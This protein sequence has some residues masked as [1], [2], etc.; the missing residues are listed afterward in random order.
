MTKS[1]PGL[2]KSLQ[3]FKSQLSN[4][5]R[6]SWP[7]LGLLL[8]AL[9]ALVIWLVVQVW[10]EAED[11]TWQRINDTGVIRVCTDPSWPPFEFID[12]RTTEI[13]GLD[14]DLASAVAA[15]LRPEGPPIRAELVPVGFDS[16]YDALLAGRCDA[17]LSA[18][19]YEP[20]RTEDVAYA[21]SYFNA[22]MVIV[23]RDGSADIAGLDNLP[24]RVVG[25]EWG[26]VPEGNSQQRLLL[27]SLSLRRYD[28]AL[29]VLRALQSGEIE[30]ALVD[31][32]SALDY[33]YQCQGLHIVGQPFTDVSYV[34]PVR[35]DAFRL[36][37]E[38]NR[39]LIE[40]REDETLSGLLNKWF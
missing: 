9:L 19:P 18:L 17:V 5:P 13:K 36:L 29:D 24:G 28:T 1:P 34:I 4:L 11:L 33:L 40:M 31:Q 22:G 27:Q 38:L 20:E 15:R 21:I 2:R 26:F 14:I 16:L 8:A 39:V 30:T 12:E 6:W 32:V 37:A 23:V 7:L 25:V 10:P 3:D 35:L